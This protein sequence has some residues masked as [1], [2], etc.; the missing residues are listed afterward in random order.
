MQYLTSITAQG[1]EICGYLQGIVKQNNL[2][3]YFKLNTEVMKAEW[4]DET[5]KWTVT[6][7]DLD[8]G[9][10]SIEVA[11]GMTLPDKQKD[12]QSH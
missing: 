11:D 2:E 1:Q 12:V 6:L 4:N 7:K 9:K 5:S 3:K 8:T 10:V